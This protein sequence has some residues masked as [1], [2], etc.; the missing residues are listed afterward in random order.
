MGRVTAMAW[1]KATV[2]VRVKVTARALALVPQ[3]AS[4]PPVTL[5][6]RS[7]SQRM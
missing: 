7:S 2:Q 6:L 3:V 4:N 1:V 5:M